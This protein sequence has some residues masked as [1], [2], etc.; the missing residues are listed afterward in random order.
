MLPAMK[1][2]GVG[3]ILNQRYRVNPPSGIRAQHRINAWINTNN[4]WLRNMR[5]WSYEDAHNKIGNNIDYIFAS[6]YLKVPEYKLVLNYS[7]LTV[8]G[9]MP[10]DHNMMRA[11]IA[12]P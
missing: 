3:D 5:T 6:N 7:G 1:N 11:T 2:A 8:Q 12:I 4:H 10:S 9:T